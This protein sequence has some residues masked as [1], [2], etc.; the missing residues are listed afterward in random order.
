MSEHSG[1]FDFN[2]WLEL[3]EK[4]RNYAS[5]DSLNPTYLRKITDSELS[6][7]LQQAAQL[8][9]ASRKLREL[10]VQNRIFAEQ[11]RQKGREV[12][13]QHSMV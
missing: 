10:S 13:S 4:S 6:S 12:F 11:V 8:R 9:D 1:V 3:I 2:K 7:S 5:S